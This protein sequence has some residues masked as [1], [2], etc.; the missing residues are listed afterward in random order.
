ML[1]NKIV[2]ANVY[3]FGTQRRTFCYKIDEKYIDCTGSVVKVNFGNRNL[4]GVI[5]SIEEC[6]IVNSKVKINNETL[7]ISKIKDVNDIVY[8]N[9]LSEKFLSFLQKMAW[10]N[11]IDIERLLEN[12]IPNVWL[13]KKKEL[14]TIDK[15]MKKSRNKN[16]KAQQL[17]LNEQ[18][19]QIFKNIDTTNFNV[20]LIRGV[21][22]SGKTYILLALIKKKLLEDENSQILIM[23]PEIALTNNLIDIVYNITGVEPIIWHSSVSSAKKKIYYENI[24]NGHVRIVISTRSGL[25][26]PYKN[27]SMI[28]IDEEH[29]RSYKQDEIPCYHARDMAILR[30]KYENIPVI[31][32]SA[33]PSIETI[34]NVM[35]NKYKLYTINNKFFDSELPKIELIDMNIKNI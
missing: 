19:E 18:Q 12:V 20:S 2:I 11:V 5:L 1:F 14:K 7:D 24:I 32:C 22:G 15:I 23:V 29:D 26:L 34:V 16:N 8:K 35:N 13:N 4:F 28:V 10:Y 17:K 3:C 6:E 9:L 33:T 25:L 30:A 31:L 27:L 21:M